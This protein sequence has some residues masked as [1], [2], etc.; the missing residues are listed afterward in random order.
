MLLEVL[1]GRELQDRRFRRPYSLLC[2]FSLAGRPHGGGFKPPRASGVVR[3][4]FR[5]R[6]VARV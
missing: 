6:C 3:A 1:G 5:V 4:P 2:F